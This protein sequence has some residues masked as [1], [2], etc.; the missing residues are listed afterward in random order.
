MKITFKNG[1]T[2][3]VPIDGTLNFKQTGGS[4]QIIHTASNGVKTEYTLPQ[5]AQVDMDISEDKPVQIKSNV[6]IPNVNITVTDSDGNRAVA[7][8]TI[9]QN[10]N[11]GIDAGDTPGQLLTLTSDTNIPDVKVTTTSSD[12]SRVD[13]SLTI[14][15]RTDTP[16]ESGQVNIGVTEEGRL[17]LTGNTEIP[18]VVVQTRSA[19][20]VVNT[21]LTVPKN[22]EVSI[23][24]DPNSGETIIGTKIYQTQGAI[25]G[26][27]ITTLVDSEIA[28]AAVPEGARVTVRKV[29]AIVDGQKLNEGNSITL[30]IGPEAAEGSPQEIRVEPPPPEEAPPRRTGS[31]TRP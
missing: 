11:V 27:A 30:P 29:G 19:S 18:R 13:V 26:H 23:G 12:G 16:G 22:G 14:P 2:Q 24:Q 15:G 28:I 31:P 9:P 4:T 20:N 25:G 5:G 6:P 3:I 1:E 8:L 10:A 17:S 21:V 7:T